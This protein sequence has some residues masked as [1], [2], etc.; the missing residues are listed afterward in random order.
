MEPFRLLS[1]CRLTLCSMLRIC[2]WLYEQ[3]TMLNFT[4]TKTTNNFWKCASCLL[5]HETSPVAAANDDDNE[6]D[7]EQQQQQNNN[8]TNLYTFSLGRYYYRCVSVCLCVCARAVFIM[9][10]MNNWINARLA[11]TERTFA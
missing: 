11:L 2:G 4:M 6:N 1:L 10:F 9:I 8:I 3:P 7:D 5:K